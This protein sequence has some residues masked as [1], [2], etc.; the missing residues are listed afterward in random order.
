MHKR[1]F[2]VGL[3]LL[4][5]ITLSAWWTPPALAF[6][7]EQKLFS[8]AWRIVSQSY[9]DDSFNHQNWWQLREKVLQKRLD[10]RD[11]TYSAIKNMLES[12]DDPFTRF[13]TPNQYR[14]LQVKYL[15]RAIGCGVTDCS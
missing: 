4:V 11:V 13:L 3:L 7:E 8:Q 1:A 14:S 12:L 15:W 6:T 10:N 2:W 9:I 5:Q